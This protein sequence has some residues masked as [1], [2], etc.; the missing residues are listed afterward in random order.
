M[1]ADSPHEREAEHLGVEYTHF[2][3]SSIYFRG[4][5]E[6]DLSSSR[7]RSVRCTDRQ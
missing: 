3:G 5:T 6:N 2:H 1:S 7:I 4:P